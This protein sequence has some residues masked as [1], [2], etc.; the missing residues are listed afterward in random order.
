MNKIVKILNE[1]MPGFAALVANLK[2][3]PLDSITLKDVVEVAREVYG[4][5]TEFILE[6]L[7]SKIDE[8]EGSDTAEGESENSSSDAVEAVSLSIRYF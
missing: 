4:E 1:I 7:R 3:K 8:N 5:S 2:G 6:V